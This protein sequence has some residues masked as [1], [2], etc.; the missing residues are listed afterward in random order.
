VYKF[1]FRIQKK[2]GK[3]N[4]MTDLIFILPI[5]TF[6]AMFDSDGCIYV[7]YEKNIAKMVLFM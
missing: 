6:C 5:A 4:I 1:Y 7:T 3:Q 2:R